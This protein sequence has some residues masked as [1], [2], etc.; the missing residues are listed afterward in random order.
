[1]SGINSAFNI[2]RSGLTINSQWSEIV[3]GNI[4]NA[5]N[6]DYGRRTLSRTSTESGNVLATGVQR[7]A[8]ASLTRMYREELARA[9]R[10][11]ALSTGLT[12]YTTGLGSL[13]DPNSPMQLL[14]QFQTSFDFLFN[15]PGQ[16]SLQQA[17][18]Q[19]AQS[20][21]RGLNRVSNNLDTAVGETRQR[22]GSDITET[23]KLLNQLADLNT[24][25]AN[26]EPGSA[27][28]VTL[29][30]QQTASL[31]RLAE[32]VDI[33]VTPSERGMVDVRT[34]G[35][36]RLVEREGAFN[37]AYDSGTGQLTAG[38]V[39]VTPGRTTGVNEGLLAGH[40]ELLNDILPKVRL[41]IDEFARGLVQTFENADASLGAGDAG[42]FTDAGGA[43]D[44]GAL[45]GL[46][47]RITVND[48]VDPSAGGALW[49]LRD[50]IG[51]TTSGSQG[52]SSQIDAFIA[53]L[54]GPQSFNGSTGLPTGISLSEFGA[55]MI[56]NQQD[57]RARADKAFENYATSAASVDDARLNAQGVNIDDELQ[58]LLL[59]EK[60]YAANAQVISTLSDMLDALLAAT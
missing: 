16:T 42:L 31:N 27:L 2:A 4:A 54:D 57:A 36:A 26:T 20:L 28:Y 18:L 46:A 44:P 10:Q 23:N 1:M 35:G 29:E 19:S 14:N 50:G 59:I 51:A 7:A 49:R 11:D 30:D 33:K 55:A 8:D 12:A 15:D 45:T 41:Q 21:A 9:M 47:G 17:T 32:Y 38:G 13:D 39:D 52:D 37:L 3:S 40:V 43:Y 6:A 53:A 60:S 25:M 58:Q 5:D 24:K 56:A 34:M 22:L 48:A